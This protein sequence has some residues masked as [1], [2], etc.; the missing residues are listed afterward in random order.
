M[1]L[2]I[3]L[4]YLFFFSFIVLTSLARWFMTYGML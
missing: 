4:F 1:H 3:H 2:F